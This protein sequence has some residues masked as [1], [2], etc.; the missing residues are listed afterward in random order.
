MVHLHTSF[1]VK[2][3]N[4]QSVACQLI[5]V[6]PK[7]L[8]NLATHLEQEKSFSNLTSEEWYALDLLKK[9]NTISAHITLGARF[10]ILIK[11][12]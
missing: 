1:T 5:A 11:M 12:L 9:V 3:S 7:V 2:N 8:I 4:F 10:N 6:S